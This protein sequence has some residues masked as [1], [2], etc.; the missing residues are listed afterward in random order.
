MSLAALQAV[1][2]LEHKPLD[3][4]GEQLVRL[5]KYFAFKTLGHDMFSP[6]ERFQS[7][8]A[9]RARFLGRAA[10]MPSPPWSIGRVTVS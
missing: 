2:V 9:R 8:L 5:D 6:K 4:H 3:S 10:W 7:S 1:Q